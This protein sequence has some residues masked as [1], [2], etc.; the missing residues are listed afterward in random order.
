MTALRPLASATLFI[1]Y[2]GIQSIQIYQE[3]NTQFLTPTRIGYYVSGNLTGY[4]YDALGRA[5]GLISSAR[6][7]AARRRRQSTKSSTR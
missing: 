2:D 6:R 5:L 4:I 7:A 3:S 1:S